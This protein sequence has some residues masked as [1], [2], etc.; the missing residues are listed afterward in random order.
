MPTRNMDV[1]GRI[2][3]KA[4]PKLY[5]TLFY[6]DDGLELL[7]LVKKKN[8]NNE[9]E[10]TFELD[11]AENPYAKSAEVTEEIN[12][13]IAA[14]GTVF[15][16]KGVVEKVSDLPQENNETGDVYH[17]TEEQSEYVWIDDDGTEKWEELG[18]V[19]VAQADYALVAR[20][21][22]EADQL[23]SDRQIENADEACPPI[24]FGPIGGTAEV[25]D[26]YSKFEE[27]RG[28]TICW[29]QLFVP[30]STVTTAG[31]TVTNNG[32][33]SFTLSDTATGEV[34]LNLTDSQ[35]PISYIEG[36]KYLLR[37]GITT[38]AE[39][40]ASASSIT[41][42]WA[43]NIPIIFTAQSSAASGY[44]RVRIVNGT[45]YNNVKIIPQ[46]THTLCG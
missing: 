22:I 11:G 23:A 40:S 16:F 27:L 5:D 39:L 10:F 29:N 1:L 28:N 17:V 34:Y 37:G 43:G 45:T 33:G 8:A 42:Y 20:E 7:K 38:D 2:I 31:V 9:I 18:P 6:S 30:R 36:H 15:D 35:Y 25:Q 14:L 21:A 24:V 41:P 26:G 44:V 32:D 12:Q 4:D 46:A 19:K 13:K 3:Q